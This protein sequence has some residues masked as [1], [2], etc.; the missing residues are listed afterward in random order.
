MAV[1][2][3]QCWFSLELP[4]D[5]DTTVPYFQASPSERGPGSKISTSPFPL[6]GGTSGNRV[7]A[8][9]GPSVH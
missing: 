6:W 4:Q 9:R 7:Q 1:K 5:L 8:P 3:S 2:G